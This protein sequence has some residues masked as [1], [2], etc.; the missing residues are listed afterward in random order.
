MLTVSPL[1]CFKLWINRQKFV[2]Q[3]TRYSRSSCFLFI[4]RF[5]DWMD[6]FKSDRT[7]SSSL[8][9]S[10]YRIHMNRTYEGKPGRK[11]IA[12]R[13]FNSSIS[14][15]T[16]F[17]SSSVFH[18]NTPKYSLEFF[19]LICGAYSDR[20]TVVPFNCCV[21]FTIDLLLLLPLVVLPLAC[22]VS[23]LV[24]VFWIWRDLSTWLMSAAYIEAFIEAVED[25][26][27]APKRSFPRF[28]KSKKF[29]KVS[30]GQ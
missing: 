5:V 24:E 10:A 18:S 29:F 16:I 28:T 15:L 1:Y 20:L 27:R 8:I 11:V 25:E 12:N 14:L 6:E 13:G 2:I 30:L 4:S 22:A 19:D 9:M 3:R 26:F 7:R 23:V 21:W 17:D